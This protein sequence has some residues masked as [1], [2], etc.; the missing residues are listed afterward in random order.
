[1]KN[2]PILAIFDFCDTIFDGQ[3][4]TFFL[5]FLESKLPLYKRI[6][7][8]VMKKINKIPPS[9]SKEY[10][11]NLMQVFYGI[12]EETINKYCSEFYSKVILNRLHRCVIEA[13][14]YHKKERHIIAIVSGGFDIYLKYFARDFGVDYLICTKL[15]FKSGIFVS[16][17]LGDECL[18]NGKLELL[19]KNLNLSDYDL[20][21]SFCYSDS[22]SD[23]PLFSLVGNKVIVKN[24]QD[25]SWANDSFQILEVDRKYA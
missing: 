3:S 1:M 21:N 6:Y 14:L 2:K 22:R 5:N 11:E 10:K 16:K 8:K 25:I 9:N 19:S 4:V 12:E 24:N 17:I 7:A 15:E 20:L 23:L 13:L 18:G